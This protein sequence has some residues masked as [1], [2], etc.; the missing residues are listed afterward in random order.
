MFSLKAAVNAKKIKGAAVSFMGYVEQMKEHI[1]QR[2]ENDEEMATLTQRA[3]LGDRRAVQTSL[4]EIEQYVRHHPYAGVL[5]EEYR[6][7]D[8]T[9]ALFQ[10]WIGYAAAYPWFYERQ[11]ANSA[12]MQIIGT[13]LFFSEHGEYRAYNHQFS[14]EE[15]AEQLRRSLIRH[16][17]HVRLDHSQPSA[18]FPIV[19]PLW[20]ERLLRLSIWTEPR[21]WN[22]FETLTFRR[23]ITEHMSFDDQAGTGMIAAESV[24]FWEA[25]VATYPNLVISGQVDSGKT[26]FANTVVWEQLRQAERSMGV[27]MIEKHPESTLPMTVSGH[28]FIPIQASDSELMDVGIQSLRHDPDVVFMTEMRWS[29]W[30]LYLFAGEKAHRGLIGTYHTK[31][32]E[33]VPYQ[34]AFAVYANA[35]GSLRGHLMT[36][37]KSCEMVAVLEPLK[38]GKKK[39]IR[40]TEIV[41]DGMSVFA[42]DWIRWNPETQQWQYHA[43]ASN[44]LLEQMKRKDEFAAKR[45]VNELLKLEAKSPL[46][47]PIVQSR[48]SNAI[49][50]GG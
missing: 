46:R 32:A 28:R 40:L 14:S 22:G 6:T 30:Q 11:Y 18:E 41:F 7:L 38:H 24:P 23:Q 1:R 2:M 4:N 36:A 15:R 34:G 48:V 47:D 19:D 45:M 3:M 20:P 25:F 17:P 21:V 10:E 29:E 31:E 13:Q 8:V 16:A 35:G 39:L 33:D 5:P 37:L 12:K 9:G 26:T 43:G 42:R 27:I 44:Q 49:L 50:K